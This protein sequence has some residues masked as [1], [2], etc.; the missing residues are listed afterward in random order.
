MSEA[1]SGSRGVG[2][3]VELPG[4]L[5]KTASLSRLLPRVSAIRRHRPDAQGSPGATRKAPASP[6]TM[7]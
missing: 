3:G 5:R 6:W 1:L 7:G 4:E 2:I